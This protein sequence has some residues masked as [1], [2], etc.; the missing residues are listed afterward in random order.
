MVVEN[1][2]YLTIYVMWYPILI[3]FAIRPEM[4]FNDDNKMFFFLQIGYV[5]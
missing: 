5:R 2:P 1:F 4:R 3:S